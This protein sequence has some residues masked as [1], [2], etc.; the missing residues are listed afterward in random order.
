MTDPVDK[1]AELVRQSRTARSAF[2]ASMTKAFTD[3]VERQYPTLVAYSLLTKDHTASL[4]V[5]LAVDF[6]G[7]QVRAVG[8]TQPPQVREE[9]V[10]KVSAPLQGNANAGTE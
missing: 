1:A 8:T 7:G 6:V 2:L 10:Q 9:A 4:S 5:D 3:L